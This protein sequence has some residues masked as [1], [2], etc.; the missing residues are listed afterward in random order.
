MSG[1]SAYEQ[2]RERLQA[3]GHLER[4]GSI[5]GWDQEVLMPPKAVG[6]RAESRVFLQQE[7]QRR[8][9]EDALG[10]L[11]EAAAA[12]ALGEVAAANVRG[13]QRARHHALAVPPELEAE[14]TRHTTLS[15]EAWKS[16]RASDD[17][18]RFAGELARTVELTREKAAHLSPGGDPYEALM[19][20]Y[21]EGL[22]RARMDGVF[23]TLSGPSMAI[24]EARRD[25][26]A[27]YDPAADGP[28]SGDVQ[29]AFGKVAIGWLGFDLQA[30]RLDLSAHPF[31]ISFGP[32][33]VRLTTRT[34]ESD[35]FS[36][37]LACLHEAGHGLYEA[38]LPESHALEPVGAAVSLGVHE[39]QSRLWENMV[40]RGVGF[41]QHAMATVREHFP[42]AAGIDEATL[43][44]HLTRVRPGLIRVEADEVCYNLHIQ[45][46]YE[47]E[48]QLIDGDL[49]VA[50]LPAA[51]NEWMERLLGVQVPS[52][53]DGVLQ[54][55]HWAMGALGYFPTYTLGNVYSAQF[56]AAA[57]REMPD[58][59]AGLAQGR[60]A[61]LL[62]WLRDR[63]HQH[64]SRWRPEALIERA[65]GAPPST[66]HL[67]DWLQARYASA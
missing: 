6:S 11:I 15:L 40:G 16:A 59:E 53:A 26:R 48:Q 39:S 22:T 58:L 2:L 66:H 35:P 32:S 7:V 44:S 45:L 34:D 37:L 24:I 8:W 33:D 55:I 25:E 57:T 41:W 28:W 46:R 30:G 3:I 29:L 56:W 36:N 47:L 27:A 17:W 61:P 54:D 5:I 4:L 64:G 42:Q 49:A 18:S 31:S 21:E 14:L 43:V 60:T 1:A 23:A 13:A 12:E 62:N 10:E 51:W 52:H 19:D 20:E 67:V 50:D 65:T 38:G 9:R 63:V